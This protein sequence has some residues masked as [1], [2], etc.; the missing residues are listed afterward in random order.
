MARAVEW[1][2]LRN[3]GEEAVKCA[4]ESGVEVEHFSQLLA[5]H[6]CQIRK[7]GSNSGHCWYEPQTLEF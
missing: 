4:I 7:T 6:R 3:F 1:V 5:T 2:A